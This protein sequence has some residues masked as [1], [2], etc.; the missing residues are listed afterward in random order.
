L[1]KLKDKLIKSVVC[2]ADF[3]AAISLHKCASSLDQAVCCGCHLQFG[4]RRKRHN[5]YNCGLVFCKAC[6]SRKSTRASLAPDS[7]K[8]YRVCDE[9]YTKLS[10]VADGKKSEKFRAS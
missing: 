4:F 1:L 10:T 2:G 9:C 8:P 3:T 6:S 7:F 5:C